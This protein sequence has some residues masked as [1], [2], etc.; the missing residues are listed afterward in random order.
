MGETCKHDCLCGSKERLFLPSVFRG[1]Y[2]GTRP[3]F[4]CAKCGLVKENFTGYPRDLMFYH[5]KI[6]FLNKHIHK[7]REGEMRLIRDGLEFLR[8]ESEWGAD[9]HGR[10][11]FFISL[12]HK[13]TTV[14]DDEI[15]LMFDNRRLR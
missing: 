12:I 9:K 7:L 3:Y 10:E 6:T 11:S 5:D 2:Q 8:N 13:Y 1:S 4:W 15:S 14:T